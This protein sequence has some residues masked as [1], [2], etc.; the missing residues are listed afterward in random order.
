MKERIIS[1]MQLLSNSEYS[2]E[3]KIALTILP[4]LILLPILTFPISNDHSIYLRGGEAILSGKTLYVDYLDLKPP[5]IYYIY[6]IFRFFFGS[7]EFAIRYADFFYQSG[8]IILLIAVL[9]KLLRDD[10]IAYI[11]AFFYAILYVVLGYEIELH[12]EAL[13]VPFL[14]LATYLMVKNKVH[15][16]EYLCAGLI[17]GLLTA[18]K[19]TFGVVSVSAVIYILLI[20]KTWRL[21][22]TSTIRLGL[23]IVMGFGVGML[24]V[25]L[26]PTMYEGL[27]R[28]TTYLR[29]YSSIQAIDVSLLKTSIKSLGLYLGDNYSLT[30]SFFSILGILSYVFRNND[31]NTKERNDS[32]LTERRLVLFSLMTICLLFLSVAIEAK[33]IP[34]H[35]TRAYISLTI[36][37]GIGVLTTLR[38]GLLYYNQRNP[39]NQQILIIDRCVLIVLVFLALTFS[40]FS[41]YVAVMIPTIGFITNNGWYEKSYDRREAGRV[42]YPILRSAVQYIVSHKSIDEKTLCMGMG[43]AQLNTLIHEPLWSI[44]GHSQF[45]FSNHVAPEWVGRF[46]KEVTMADWII[47]ATNDEFPFQNGHSR[48]SYQSLQQDSLIYPYFLEHFREV[49]KYEGLLIFKRVKSNHNT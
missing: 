46:H 45:Y 20:E 17:I 42:G 24:P 10:A 32:L 35:F 28:M 29:Y 33:F 1:L 25:F 19:Y 4:C 41:R 2:K 12:C 3:M 34:M 18:L 9:R 11:V 14:I 44:F 23:G 5:M 31:E 16:W 43:I 13:A 49:K 30:M 22:I 27:I 6:A 21:R 15:Y 39:D 36:L 7:S 40:P 26:N 37:A 8:S 38:R 47:V 48:T